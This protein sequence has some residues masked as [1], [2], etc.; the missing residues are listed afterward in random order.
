MT[1]RG[2]ETASTPPFGKSLTTNGQANS[3]HRDY[4]GGGHS[5]LS[6]R[7]LANGTLTSAISSTI[8]SLL[9]GEAMGRMT[10]CQN[11]PEV[12]A[13][14]LNGCEMLRGLPQGDGAS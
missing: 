2:S 5:G 12:F 11:F 14:R 7:L 6:R 13:I 4:E 10:K 8:A 1:L 3:E 9:Y